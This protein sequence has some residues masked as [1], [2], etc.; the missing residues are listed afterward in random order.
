MV[1]QKGLCP[2]EALIQNLAHVLPIVFMALTITEASGQIQG[3]QPHQLGAQIF[4][5]GHPFWS[6][7]Q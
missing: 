1:P 2:I 6:L 5:L 3:H 4:W 7:L